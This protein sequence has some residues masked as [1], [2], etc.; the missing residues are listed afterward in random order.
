MQHS[1]QIIADCHLLRSRNN[2]QSV[3]DCFNYT[4]TTGG[5][6]A[7]EKML[8]TKHGNPDVIC[9]VQ[10]A[11]RFAQ[12]HD[13]PLDFELNNTE[14]NYIGQYFRSTFT[15]GSSRINFVKQIRYRYTHDAVYAHTRANV[16]RIILL[17]RGVR[18][19]AAVNTNGFPA[20]IK[21]IFDRVKEIINDKQVSLICML[22]IKTVS[23][24]QIVSADHYLRT[25]FTVPFEELL[26]NIFRLEAVLSVAR[27]TTRLGLVFPVLSD[28]NE[29]RLQHCFHLLI[30]NAVAN[31]F[32]MDDD[33]HVLLLTGANMAGKSSFL[34]S[35]ATVV[36]L[37]HAGFPVPASMAIIPFYDRIHISMSSADNLLKGYSHFYQEILSITNLLTHLDDG[38]KCFAIFDEIFNGTNFNDAMNCSAL[39]LQK[40]SAH[41]ES[42][43]FISSHNMQLAGD[44]NP[45]LQYK[46]IDS[47]IVDNKPVFSYKLLPGKN[48]IALGFFL[49]QQMQA[50]G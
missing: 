30:P 33:K 36:C 3:F 17:L 38:K 16:I 10:D 6:L 44:D 26:D 41:K 49:F 24:R 19:K 4:R 46:Y 12:K 15:S 31:D 1:E 28:K 8:L 11:I 45:M 22:D 27:A 13:V 42:L 2:E 43:V 35:V 9:Q 25:K 18:K 21:K 23:P 14:L 20:V 5:A 37:A 29:F 39:F 40:L 34:R 50:R 7:L 48:E 32:Q 47:S